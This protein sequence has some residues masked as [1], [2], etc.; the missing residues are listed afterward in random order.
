MRKRKQGAGSPSLIPGLALP[1]PCEIHL[2]LS[3]YICN[4]KVEQTIS[5]SNKSLSNSTISIVNSPEQLHL[6]VSLS[7]NWTTNTGGPRVS[8]M[9]LMCLKI[10]L[11]RFQKN[12]GPEP[13][14]PSKP[15]ALR[16]Q[17]SWELFINTPMEQEGHEDSSSEGG[18]LKEWSSRLVHFEEEKRKN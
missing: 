1:L 9:K 3:F 15:R 2:D 6:Q 11:R 18:T 4:R 7:N 5:T 14:A 16:D 10:V 17:Q 12:S 8:L 13:E